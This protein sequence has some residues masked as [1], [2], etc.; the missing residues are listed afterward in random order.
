MV[1]SN[2]SGYQDK[3]MASAKRND[4]SSELESIAAMANTHIEELIQIIE[5]LDDKLSEAI[6]LLNDNDI[7]HNI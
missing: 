2:T 6:K 7:S 5:E 1:L 4:I 3:T